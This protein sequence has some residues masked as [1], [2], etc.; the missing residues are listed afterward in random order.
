MMRLTIMNCGGCTDEREDLRAPVP[1]R[2]GLHSR[3]LLQ[4]E[5]TVLTFLRNMPTALSN[6]PLQ[7]LEHGSAVVIRRLNATDISVVS[8][9]RAADNFDI[10]SV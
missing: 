8:K 5:L 4:C 7:S 3:A 10:V 2:R 1:P 6:G 9:P